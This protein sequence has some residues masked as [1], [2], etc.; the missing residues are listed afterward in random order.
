MEVVVDVAVEDMVE[1]V[2]EEDMEVEAMAAA[3]AA[4]DMEVKSSSINIST[5]AHPKWKRN[6]CANERTFWIWNPIRL[7]L[8]YNKSSKLWNLTMTCKA[9]AADMVVAVEVVDMEV[10]L[11]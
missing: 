10:S 11:G 7:K 4:V 9:V 3:V 8:S 5:S 6:L 1:A 2:V